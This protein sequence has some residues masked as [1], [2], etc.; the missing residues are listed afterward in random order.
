[1]NYIDRKYINLLNINGT[2]WDH[3]NKKCNVRCMLCGDSKK[4]KH[5]KRGWFLS[6][7]NQP[8]VTVF[9]CFNCGV[10]TN[11]NNIL[12]ELNPQL[13]KE[14]KYEKYIEP[15]KE[16]KKVEEQKPKPAIINFI[17]YND[18]ISNKLISTKCSDYLI[19]KRNFSLKQSKDF[20]YVDNFGEYLQ[21][22]PNNEKYSNSFK[23]TFPKIVIPF[24]DNNKNVHMMQ[25]RSVDE[26]DK[27]RYMTIRLNDNFPKIWG[28]HKI[29][30]SKRIYVCEGP[31]DASFIDN[32][33]AMGGADINLKGLKKYNQEIVYVFDNERRNKQIVDRMYKMVDQGY[34][35]FLWPYTDEKDINDYYNKHRDLSIFYDTQ[36]IHKGFKAKMEISR[37]KRC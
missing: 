18:F 19:N 17:K 23:N 21:T 4:N 3:D 25:F 28:L 32:G 26:H 33:L 9:K 8:N 10:T 36:Y 1:M 11:L 34:S 22:L 27:Q 24:F 16:D 5:K 35:I 14:Y 2:K 15:F 20:F 7:H 6:H 13:Y 30:V 12:S 29:N 31:F 37:W